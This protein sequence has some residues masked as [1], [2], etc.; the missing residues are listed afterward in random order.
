VQLTICTTSLACLEQTPP[1]EP[2]DMEY[3]PT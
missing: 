2:T 3:T 1:S